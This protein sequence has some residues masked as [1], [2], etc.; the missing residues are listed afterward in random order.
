MKNKVI[1]YLICLGGILLAVSCSTRDT[2]MKRHYMKGYYVS[3]QERAHSPA[4]VKHEPRVREEREITTS[5]SAS[6][7]PEKLNEPILSQRVSGDMGQLAAGKMSNTNARPIMLEKRIQK[8]SVHLREAMQLK[9][10]LV[11]DSSDGLSLFWIVILVILILWAVGFLAGGFGI[12][13]LINL[14]LVVA[15]VLL[16]LWL[17]RVI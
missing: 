17:L 7:K 13:N 12:G 6:L 2:I 10:P 9:K 11:R 16:I 14:L 1:I 3:K 8:P 4:I 5:L 15:L